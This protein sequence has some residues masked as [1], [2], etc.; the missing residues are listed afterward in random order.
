MKMAFSFISREESALSVVL[1]R[2]SCVGSVRQLHACQSNLPGGGG[3]SPVF[4]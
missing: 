2:L 1:C 3:V 4:H